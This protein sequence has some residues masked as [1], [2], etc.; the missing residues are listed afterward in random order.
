MVGESEPMHP[1]AAASHQKL[2]FRT[3]TMFGMVRRIPPRDF[4]TEK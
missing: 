2:Q 1:E 3:L 4:R